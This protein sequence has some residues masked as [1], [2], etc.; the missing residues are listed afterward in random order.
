MLA[1]LGISL[2][3][4]LSGETVVKGI[5]S[6][7]IGLML[8][9][10][11][12][13]QISGVQRFTFNQ[14]FLWDGIGLVAVTIGIFAI[15]ETIDL[16]IQGSS[17]AKEHLGKL[18]GVFQGIK[19]TFRHL[20]LVLR[21][22]AIGTYTG[23]VPGMGGTVG[24][25]IAYAHAVQSAS[26]EDKQ[27]FGKG[28]VEGVL[29]PG[30][31]NNSSF[32]GGL[33]PTI[34]FGIPGNIPSAI[35]LG[36]FIIQGLVP[37]PDMLLPSQ[38]GGHLDLTFSLVWII[39]ISNVITVSGFF[40]FLRQMAKVTQL[41]S[42]LIIPVILSLVY[43][44]AFAEKNALPDLLVVLV[45]GL[46]GWIMIRFDWPRPPL[47]LGLVLGPLAEQRLFLSASRYG[48]AWLLRPGVIIIIL[49]ILATLFYPVIK[50]HLKKRVDQKTTGKGSIGESGT[51]I[52]DRSFRVQ[53]EAVFSF[54]ILIVFVLALWNSRGWNLRAGLF[55][56]V[57]GFTVLPLITYQFI[58]NLVGQG[59]TGND[60]DQGRSEQDPSSP[61]MVRRT[62]HI[63]SW[64]PGF[65][66]AI[67]LLG[68]IVALP[69]MT[70][71][72]LKLEARE[73]WSLSLILTFVLWGFLYGLFVH[74][75]HLPFPV[76]ILFNWS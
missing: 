74:T 63:L 4:S 67:W 52:A 36:A 7:G 48:T 23:I 65:L 37:G 29:G 55:P 73:K 66:A 75:L 35:L 25:W 26:D 69:L 43:L 50:T 59:K 40:V 54:F 1:I 57:I 18:G 62:I 24:Q 12:M 49:L 21:C 17:I 58:K 8:A 46:I 61:M 56:W 71:L 10:V 70:F 5:V 39:V 20:G 3:A 28:A 11:G 60:H 44:G 53:G 15:P 9:S 38:K 31:A 14:I 68:L 16:A 30:A 51:Q 76:G 33:I 2:I 34:A 45:F 41:R 13:N 64:I 6:G 22:S 72:Y 32:G 42:G 27:R 47:I 19:D